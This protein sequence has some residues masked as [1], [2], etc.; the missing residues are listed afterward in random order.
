MSQTKQIRKKTGRKLKKKTEH[1]GKKELAATPYHRINSFCFLSSRHKVLCLKIENDPQNKKSQK[2]GRNKLKAPKI[3]E[4]RTRGNCEAEASPPQTKK[5]NS[6]DPSGSVRGIT[7]HLIHDSK[8]STPVPCVVFHE[9]SHAYD[10][11]SI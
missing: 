7:H 9:E 2:N 3:L 11:G 1:L 10:P 5:R 6:E 8:T 4:K